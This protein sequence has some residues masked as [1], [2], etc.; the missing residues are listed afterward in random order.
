MMS[1]FKTV[2]AAAVCGCVVFTSAFAGEIVLFGAPVQISSP[3]QRSLAPDIDLGADGTVHVLWVS[4]APPPTR[5]AEHST[6][7]NHDATDELFYRRSTDDGKR[8]GE[9]VRVNRKSGDVWGFAVSKPE[10]SVAPDG[11]IHVMYTSNVTDADTGKGLLVARYARSVDDGQT[12]EPARTL[13]SAAKN[14]LSA[15]M[16]GGFAAAHAFGTLTTDA[17]GG[18]HVY[19]IDTRFMAEQDTVG[20]LFVAT[21]RDNGE[22]FAP[23]SAVYK[24]KVCPCCQLDADTRGEQVYL[25][26]RWVFAEGSRDSAVAVSNDS[27]RTFPEPARLGEG[28]WMIEG[29]PLKRTAI[30]VAGEQVYTAWFTAGQEPAGVYFAGS[31]DGGKT[32]QKSIAMHPDALVSDAPSIAALDD[33]T[34]FVAWHA[35]IGGPRR[36]FIAVSTDYGAS[37]SAPIEV[38]APE[39]TAAYPE[40]VAGAGGAYLAWQQ[41]ESTF[42]IA[43]EL[44]GAVIAAQR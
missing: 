25:S 28:R 24:G 4:K 11:S 42:V 1:D 38:P 9:P 21:S 27:G 13:N 16:H 29:C 39:G 20:A 6:G 10:L 41:D 32:Y 12:F 7:M 37:F 3:D 33:G 43:L 36:V 40:I 26:S 5:D 17:N 22:T 23:D 19:W 15:V 14:D 30:D 31:T 18:V 8:F 44:A 2:T 34:V 35:K